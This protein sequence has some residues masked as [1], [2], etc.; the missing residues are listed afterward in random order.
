M[1][2]TPRNEYKSAS[3]YPLLNF[4]INFSA[5]WVD[6]NSFLHKFALHFEQQVHFWKQKKADVVKLVDTLDLGSSASRCVGSS[7]SIRT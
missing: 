6:F 1:N 3:S 2:R 5:Y 7:P 4:F